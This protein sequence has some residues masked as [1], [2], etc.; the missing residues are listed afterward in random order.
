MDGMEDSTFKVVFAGSEGVGKTTILCRFAE[1]TFQENIPEFEM[2]K[3]VCNVDGKEYALAFFDTAGQERFRTLTSGYY[4]NTTAAV[5]VY[6][7]NDEQSY[8]ELPNWVRD[9]N[10]YGKEPVLMILANKTD[11]GKGN[12]DLDEAQSYAEANRCKFFAVSAKEGTNMD[13]A[14][15]CLLQAIIKKKGGETQPVVEEKKSG[16]CVIM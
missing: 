12:I 16:C 13:E 2:K 8:T 14:F 1:G 6:D 9:V 10:R 7:V 5:I 3:R 11:L 15:D 4:T